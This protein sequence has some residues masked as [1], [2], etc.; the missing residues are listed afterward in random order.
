[1]TEQPSFDPHLWFL[2]ADG[3]EIAGVTLCKTLAGE[4]WVDVVAVRRR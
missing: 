2:A 4:G 3:D 1:M